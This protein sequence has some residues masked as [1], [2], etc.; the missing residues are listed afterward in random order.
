[1]VTLSKRLTCW[2]GE[3]TNFLRFLFNTGRG[4][5]VYSEFKSL[6]GKPRAVSSLLVQTNAHIHCIEW[7]DLNTI[8]NKF[9]VFRE[10]FLSRMVF[11]YQI[12][13]N[14]KVSVDFKFI[15]GV[16]KIDTWTRK[17][18]PNFFSVI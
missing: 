6:D 7:S 12:G 16:F 4:D 15:E 1:M 13:D 9:P 2:G 8:L 14:V 10:D 17:Y 5:T 11:S 18:R 3:F